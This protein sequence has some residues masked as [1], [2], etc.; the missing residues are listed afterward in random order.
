VLVEWVGLKDDLMGD[1]DGGQ[2]SDEMIETLIRAYGAPASLTKS[3]DKSLSV[4]Y[5]DRTNR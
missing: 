3:I 5:T 2:V 4:A 1:P